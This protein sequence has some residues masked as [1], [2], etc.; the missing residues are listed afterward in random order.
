MKRSL[1]I[2]LV[3]IL[4]GSTGCTTTDSNVGSLGNDSGVADGSGQVARD[5]QAQP[6]DAGPIS[7]DA[8]VA[9]VATVGK[10]AAPDSPAALAPDVA[11]VTKDALTPDTKTVAKDAA[12]DS[13]LPDAA[14]PDVASVAKDAASESPEAGAAHRCQVSGNTC[15]AITPNTECMPFIGRLF[16]E[17]AGCYSAV[18]TILGCCA[19]AA[20]ETCALPTASGC[21]ESATVSTIAYWTPYQWTA[22]VEMLPGGQPC[23]SP[24]YGNVAAAH[25]CS[26]AAADAASA[27]P[28][29]GAAHQCQL[30]ADGTCS[31]VTPNT[32]CTPFNARR[33]DESAGCLATNWTTLWCC[34]TAAGD[35]CGWPAATGCYQVAADGGTVTYWTPALP[36]PSPPLPA[37]QACDQSTSAKVS[38]ASVSLCAASPVDAAA[39]PDA[40]VPVSLPLC[41]T[42]DDCCVTVDT[43]YGVATLGGKAGWGPVPGTHAAGDVCPPCA[44]PAVQVQCRGGFCFGTRVGSFAPAGMEKLAV[45]HCGYIYP[46]DG[47]AAPAASP[48][49]AVDA[50][51]SY[52]TTWTGGSY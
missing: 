49:A 21:Y 28:E 23:G 30:N 41:A 29:A 36:P 6:A 19:T 3:S 2:L 42:D 11:D 32:A 5:V 25:P 43:C 51:L 40:H 37:G 35:S 14:V 8:V 7:S 10:D 1:F 46:P 39:P 20:G 13:P 4:V 48:H 44:A 45:S 31:A 38:S 26:P 52:Q 34:A 12:P 27:P 16:D 9:D 18:D 24:R 47:G 33:Y 17:G 50:G 15:K 22:A